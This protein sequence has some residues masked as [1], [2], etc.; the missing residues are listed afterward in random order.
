V[1]QVIDYDRIA[2]DY[3]RHRQVHPE[4]LRSLVSTSRVGRASKV[5]EVGCG[6][7]NYILA[8]EQLTGAH[9]W[10]IDP[11]QGMLSR[12]RD[13]SEVVC[14]R[15][16]RAE[17]LD[18]S[19]GFF[20][21]VFCVD[22]IHHITD[23]F[24]YFEEAQRVLKGGGKLCTVTDSEWI[25]RHRQPLAVYFPET[26]E[27]ELARYPRISELRALM[28]QAGFCGVTEEQ[29]EFPYQLN[30]TRA[31]RE[32][33]FSSLHLIPENAFQRGLAHM[34]QDLR[35]GPIPCV[36]RYVLLWGTT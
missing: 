19:A 25:I 3:A 30:D 8:L 26:V 13:R 34:E 16:G 33:A 28:A 2:S 32:K 11:S 15:A 5:L 14:F 23:R 12:A 4:V 35:A 10:G 29:V 1:V 36:S 24:A 27:P 9:G 20:D 18:F 22:V 7:G 6:T 17:K 21:L 31:Y